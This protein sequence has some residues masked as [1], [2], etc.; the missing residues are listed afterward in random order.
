MSLLRLFA[1]IPLPLI[2][3]TGCG[4]SQ[5]NR[6]CRAAAFGAKM[7]QGQSRS[8]KVNQTDSGKAEG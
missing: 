7:G 5:P 3:L 8:I 4:A 1:A 2:L 6:A